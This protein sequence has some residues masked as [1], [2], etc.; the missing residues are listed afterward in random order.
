MAKL[1]HDQ[2]KALD[3]IISW[4]KSSNRSQFITLGGFAGTGK[5]TLIGVLRSMLHKDNKKLCVAFCSYTGKATRVMRA[6]LLMAKSVHTQDSVSTIHGLIYSPV[7]DDNEQITGWKRKDDITCDLVIVDEASMVNQK[8]WDDLLSYNVPIIAVGDHGQ[9]PPIRG[10]FNLMEDPDLRLKKIHRQAK[11][12]PIIEVSIAAR[13]TG[14]IPIGC[15]R[16]K[17]GM[18]TKI[19]QSDSESQTEIGEWLSNYNHDTLVLCGY[20]TTR[21]KINKF[22][23]ESLGF[24]TPIPEVNDRVICLRNNH[25]AQVYNGMLGTILSI[26]SKN[27]NWYQSEIQMDDEVDTYDGLISVKQF[28]SPTAINF[29]RDRSKIMDGDLFDFGYALTVHKAQGSQAQR[30]ILF[31]E[32][33]RQMD[34]EMWKKWLYTAVTRAENELFVVGK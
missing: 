5:T 17:S 15:T 12:N 1:S 33:F 6:K 29:T 2:Q 26:S 10:H 23:R 28:D 22:I 7:I 14:Q 25:I 3:A 16:S 8:I 18:V 21:L 20:N 32:R 27:D 9:L 4:F 34:D 11:N 30:V 24:E 19:L 13:T 31:E